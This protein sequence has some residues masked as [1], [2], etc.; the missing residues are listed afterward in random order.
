MKKMFAVAIAATAL[1]AGA[2]SASAASRTAY[3]RVSL[4]ASQDVS[5]TKQLTYRTNCGSGFVQLR[6]NGESALRMRTPRA[7]PAVAQLHRNGQVT[8]RFRGGGALLPVVGTLTRHGKS[9][10]TGQTPET[11][12]GCP[13][14][15]L[16]VTPDCGTRRFGGHSS[17]GVSYLTPADSPDREP[18]PDLDLA[19][20]TGRDF[21]L[22]S[23]TDAI[24]LTG[25]SVPG[26]RGVVFEWCPGANGD[27]VLRGSVY[28]PEGAHSTPGRLPFSRLFGKRSLFTV[29]ERSS[30]RVDTFPNSGAV[31]GSFPIKTETDWTL[32]FKR[33]A[34]RPAGL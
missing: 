15:G 24:V 3:F 22:G 10:A 23:L 2:Q 13:K 4:V 27:D 19:P 31:S 5:W 9:Y 26:W 11:S 20:L 18:D 7:Q 12:S 34:H 32:T 8:L 6:G 14:P 33:L 1:L 21:N 25:P 28:E 17:V 29:N 16:P 30:D